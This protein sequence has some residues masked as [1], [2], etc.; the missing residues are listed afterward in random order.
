MAPWNGPNHMHGI[1]A[2]REFRNVFKHF[3]LFLQRFTS[4]VGYVLALSSAQ[5]YA[6]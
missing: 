6:K 1:S 5:C 2:P 4:V 3:I